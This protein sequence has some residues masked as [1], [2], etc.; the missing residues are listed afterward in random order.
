[1][2]TLEAIPEIL[3]Q[4]AL[5]QLLS[6]PSLIRTTT[7]GKRIQFLSPGRINVHEGPD[8][9]DMAILLDSTVIVGHG[10]FHRK[11]SD[12]IAHN[13]SHD[14]R[15]QQLAVH[16]VCEVD[17]ELSESI[18]TVIVSSD[19]LVDIANNLPPS[20]FA[21]TT[22]EDV[23]TYSLLRLLRMTAECKEFLKAKTLGQTLSES[24]KSF[25][26]RFEKK[27]RRPVYARERLE[28]LY[29]AISTSVHARFLINIQE[30]AQSGLPEGINKTILEQ[31]YVL[32]HTPIF[33]EGA[34]LRREVIVN[35]ILP[36]ALAI[37][38]DQSRIALFEW[39]WSTNSL[40]EYGI[41]KRSFPEFP[42]TFLWQQQ[43][44]LEMLRE[45]NART[46]AHEAIK[47][48][49]LMHTIAFYKSALEAPE[50]QE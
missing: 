40:N 25:I 7:K 12:W 9:L 48:Y 36:I 6:D 43:G 23:H 35:C 33:D 13:H 41:L 24:L 11:T 50:I 31:L 3:L 22:I 28:Q 21:D 29:S 37:A 47:S 14:I 10:E 19:E 38:D 18:P 16:L 42:Q 5:R 8:F 34:H 15:Y 2:N 46:S 49:G 32:L 45:K 27:N 1:M 30:Y 26:V 4:R 17:V 39:Y 20:Q 44:M